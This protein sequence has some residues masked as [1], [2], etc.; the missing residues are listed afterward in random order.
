MPVKEFRLLITDVVNE[1]FNV[2]LTSHE[3]DVKVSSS[4]VKKKKIEKDKMEKEELNG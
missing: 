4:K 3:S 2:H 1:C